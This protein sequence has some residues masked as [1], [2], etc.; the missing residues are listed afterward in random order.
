MKRS[1]RTALA[2]AACVFLAAAGVPLAAQSP[3]NLELKGIVIGTDSGAGSVQSAFGHRGQKDE[4][5]SFRIKWS[6]SFGR[7]EAEAQYVALVRHGDAVF[8]DPQLSNLF[9]AGGAPQPAA[10]WWNLRRTIRS[11]GET[12][13]TQRFD[14]LFVGYA[15]DHLVLRLGRQALT[16]G[17]GLVFHPMDLFNPFS[18]NAVDTEYKPGT[19]ML[20]G[21]WLFDGGGD[22][23][24]LV[25][26]RRDPSTGGLTG[27]QA[28]VAFKWHYPGTKIQMDVMGAR[29]YGDRVFGV[30]ASGP[31]GGATWSAA[32]VSTWLEGGGSRVSILANLRSA[33]TWAGRNTSTYVEYFHNGFGTARRDYTVASLS[34]PLQ[35]R[36]VRGELF[37]T[38]RDYVAAGADVQWTP[39]VTLSPVLIA[40]LNDRS[41][42]AQVNLRVS[43]ADNLLFD[44]GVQAP[45]GP[46]GTEFGGLPLSNALPA[47]YGPGRRL[48]VEL[49]GY[50]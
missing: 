25:V 45:V 2:V 40:N 39:L 43:L 23:Q 35:A 42:L 7:F 20:Y 21:Q 48:F 33:A 28:S 5:L 6:E 34:G 8:L 13:A 26:P 50:F 47:R 29:H 17:V 27:G 18:P 41:L 12:L 24:G 16:W 14:R 11:S 38:G 19:D 36:L 30:D 4:D 10:P 49:R 1:G 44:M 3:L 9:A 37:D 32:A 31:A 46:K 22:V 15:G